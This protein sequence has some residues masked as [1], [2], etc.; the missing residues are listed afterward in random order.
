KFLKGAEKDDKATRHAL[1]TLINHEKQT[2]PVPS[3][4]NPLVPVYEAM[5]NIFVYAL[6]RRAERVEI[7]ADAKQANV[8]A[9]IDGVRYAVTQLE[10]QIGLGVIDYLKLHAG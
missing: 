1:V 9:K 7:L 6:P 3:G 2:V 4:E 8:A 10:P 5:E